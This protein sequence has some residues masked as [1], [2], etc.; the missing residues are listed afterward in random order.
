[1]GKWMLRHHDEVLQ[2]KF[3]NLVTGAIQ[4]IKLEE[5]EPKITYEA[6]VEE[7]DVGE[8]FTT[9]LIEVLVK[10]MADRR[11]RANI[12]DRRFVSERA[13]KMLRSQISPHHIYHGRRQA[14]RLAARSSSNVVY[15]DLV[16]ELTD[17]EE[18]NDSH[19]LPPEGDFPY[20]GVRINSDLYEA[21]AP[22]SYTSTTSAYDILDSLHGFQPTTLATASPEVT[23][24]RRSGDLSVNS[25]RPASPALPSITY[26]TSPWV[27]GGTS[28]ASSLT[29]QHSVRRPARS[30]TIDFNEFTD[31]RRSSLRQNQHDGDYIR[32]EESADGTWRFRPSFPYPTDEPS[33]ST[34]VTDHMPLPPP[35]RRVS[36]SSGPR[37]RYEVGGAFPWSPEPS[38]SPSLDNGDQDEQAASASGS[39]SSSQL[40]YSLT[41]PT[42]APP[43]HPTNRRA[44]IADVNEARRQVIAPRLRRGGLRAPESLLSR[45]ASPTD[46]DPAANREG[47]APIEESGGQQGEN[48]DPVFVPSIPALRN[49]LRHENSPDSAGW[50]HTGE[51]TTQ[52]PTP[53]RSVTP[54]ADSVGNA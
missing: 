35:P 1:M 39:Q 5:G 14:S 17:E 36:S 52:L 42:P 53:T 49:L 46:G 7:L 45:Y 4:R 11:T 19:S 15:T 18:A 27:H 40:W 28:H 44:S 12:R 20:E 47:T 31:R 30:R 10:E 33:S 25:P 32:S 8:T 50:R 54:A 29:R 41:Y 38:Q 51:D 48:S 43:A 2:S 34:S 16:A 13:A 21:Y 9:T 23:E 24:H 6:F 37:R 3:K 22:P 26:R